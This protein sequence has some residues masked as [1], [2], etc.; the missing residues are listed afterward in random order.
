MD[1]ELHR[2]W[3]DKKKKMCHAHMSLTKASYRFSSRAKEKGIIFLRTIGW[4]YLNKIVH[5]FRS[6]SR[7]TIM[8]FRFF[9][10]CLFS[11]SQ[12]AMDCG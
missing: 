8:E 4:M 12:L 5:A 10:S 7:A 1:V 2:P 11:P 3:I 6:H 9:F